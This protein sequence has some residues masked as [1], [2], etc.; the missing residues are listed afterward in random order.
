[1]LALLSAFILCQL[2]LDEN[3]SNSSVASRIL[4]HVSHLQCVNHIINLTVKDTENVTACGIGFTYQHGK[5]VIIFLGPVCLI[6]NYPALSA[7][8][9]GMGHSVNVL[10]SFSVFPISNESDSVVFV[11]KSKLHS[12]GLPLIIF[13]ARMYIVRSAGMLSEELRNHIGVKGTRR[14]MFPIPLHISDL[15]C[16]SKT[17]RWCWWTQKQIW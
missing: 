14:I 7:L 12:W 17:L 10:C 16:F 1:M 8:T 9:Y 6:A 3:Y 5:D 2:V 13:D 4:T 11:Y 15:F